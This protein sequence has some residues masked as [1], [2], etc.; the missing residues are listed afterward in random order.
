MSA[1]DPSAEN[2]PL[3]PE[4]KALLGRARRSFLFSLGLLLVGFIAIAVALVYRSTRDAGPAPAAY[5]AQSLRLPQGADVVSA[6]AAGGTV[7]VTYKVGPSTQMRIFDGKTGAMT[8]QLD[9]V[10]E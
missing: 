7:S 8:Q 10:T 4:A 5:A 3:S 6:V 9:I 1:P 2:Q